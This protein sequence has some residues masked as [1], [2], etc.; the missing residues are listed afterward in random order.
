MNSKSFTWTWKSNNI[1]SLSLYHIITLI[2]PC[3]SSDYDYPLH[4]ILKANDLPISENQIQDE[5]TLISWLNKNNPLLKV[6]AIN[7]R[8]EIHGLLL[9]DCNYLQ[10]FFS[11]PQWSSLPTFNSLKTLFS[12]QKL[13]THLGEREAQLTILNKSL[14]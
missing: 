7:K 6:F 3:C 1:Q 9:I 12:T 11:N 4:L 5:Q 10:S 14:D 2:F 13:V 8:E